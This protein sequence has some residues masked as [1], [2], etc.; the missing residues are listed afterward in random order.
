MLSIYK[1]V[2]SDGTINPLE[3]DTWDDGKFKKSPT[4][5]SRGEVLDTYNRG[6]YFTSESKTK[7]SSKKE[8]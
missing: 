6:Y 7:G 3:M 2:E 4:K 8:K 1:L 5:M